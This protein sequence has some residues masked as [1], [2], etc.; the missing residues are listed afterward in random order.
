M[1]EYKNLPCC[2]H[3]PRWS[4]CLQNGVAVNSLSTLLFPLHPCSVYYFFFSSC[5][6]LYFLFQFPVWIRPGEPAHSA[7]LKIEC[8]P[9]CTEMYTDVTPISDLIQT[10]LFLTLCFPVSLGDRK[11]I[12]TETLSSKWTPISWFLSLSLPAFS[13]SEPLFRGRVLGFF[14]PTLPADGT[15]QNN[16]S[17]LGTTMAANLYL[18]QRW[19]QCLGSSHQVISFLHLTNG[20]ER[21]L[22]LFWVHSTV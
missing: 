19:H 21:Y 15:W 8:T 6:H 7:V 17:W 5:W 18:S 20:T 2:W 14:V 11:Q 12:S 16:V 3:L 10:W 22:H 4:L 1:E 9:V 13:I